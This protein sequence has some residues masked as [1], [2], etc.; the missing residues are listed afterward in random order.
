LAEAAPGGMAAFSAEL[1]LD[2]WERLLRYVMPAKG[3]DLGRGA[4]TLSSRLRAEDRIVLCRR[5][6]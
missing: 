6:T 3:S 5:S 2:K 1:A 4:F